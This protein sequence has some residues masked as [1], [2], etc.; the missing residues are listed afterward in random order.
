MSLDKVDAAEWAQIARE[1]SLNKVMFRIGFLRM[2]NE[3]RKLV[4]A[5]LLPSR[6]WLVCVE[7]DTL[8]PDQ[9][10]APYVI[11]PHTYADSRVD[12][13]NEYLAGRL[14]G[15]DSDNGWF[16]GMIDAICKRIVRW[17]L[18]EGQFTLPD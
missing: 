14:G 7:F 3:G 15:G 9:K 5:E 17:I 13:I 10:D 6:R 2:P 12:K 4:L 18:D 8:Y 16:Q 11:D 1:F